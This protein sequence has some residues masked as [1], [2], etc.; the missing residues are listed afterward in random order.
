MTT[1]QA[2]WVQRT[3]T[4]AGI[5]LMLWAV[6][7]DHDSFRALSAL[8]AAAFFSMVGAGLGFWFGAPVIYRQPEEQHAFWSRFAV[9]MGSATGVLLAAVPYLLAASLARPSSTDQPDIRVVAEKPA[10]DGRHVAL[11]SITSGGGAAGYVIMNVSVRDRSQPF[12]AGQNHV[13]DM[14]HAYEVDLTWRDN[15][16]LVVEYPDVAMVLQADTH[17]G[18]ITVSYVPRPTVDEYYLHPHP[19]DRSGAFPG[20]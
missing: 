9:V 8:P 20:F 10:P 18:P 19:S 7:T 2:L 16:H 3:A 11:F 12:R 5:V 15:T 14:R 6:A 4:L 17:I 13:F 1:R